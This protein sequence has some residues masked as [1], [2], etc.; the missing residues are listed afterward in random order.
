MSIFSLHLW[1]CAWSSNQSDWLTDSIQKQ[2]LNI[3][4]CLAHKK[5]VRVTWLC[6]IKLCQS[7][8]VYIWRTKCTAFILSSKVTTIVMKYSVLHIGM[9]EYQVNC[10]LKTLRR[11]LKPDNR[12]KE[13]L[14]KTQQRHVGEKKKAQTEASWDKTTGR[15][16]TKVSFMSAQ[17]EPHK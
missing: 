2:Y 11:K 4:Q 14:L 9:S 1:S 10:H 3:I 6:L 5:K 8:F 16:A 15:Y 17:L 7:V 13:L 12:N